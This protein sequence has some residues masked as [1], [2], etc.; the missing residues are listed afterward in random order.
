MTDAETPAG[1]VF[2]TS[3]KTEEQRKLTPFELDGV[4]LSAHKPKDSV[5]L[6]ISRMLVDEDDISAVVGG[7]EKF[8]HYVFPAETR[9]IVMGRLEDADD[10]FDL[11]EVNQILTQ[12]FTVWGVI[13]E[14]GK[15]VDNSPKPARTARKSAAHR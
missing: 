10:D 7:Y 11:D 5:A 1:L 4:Q 8:M 15:P 9:A 14:D 12:L 3:V 13:D 6:W 2:T